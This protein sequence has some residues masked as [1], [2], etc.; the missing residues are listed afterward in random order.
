LP[1]QLA[2]P[3]ARGCSQ[4]HVLIVDDNVDIRGLIVSHFET[5]GIYTIGVAQ[6]QQL[7][8]YAADNR[9]DLVILDLSPPHGGGFEL[10]R[11]LRSGSGSAI[12]V[13][14]QCGEEA[15]RVVALEL[16][17]DDYV[18]KPVGLRELFARCRAVLR[19]RNTDRAALEQHQEPSGYRFGPWH[20]DKYLR[21]LSRTDGYRVT[22]SKTEYAL[23]VALLS[24]PQR[25]LSRLQLK[26]ATRIHDDITDRAMDVQIL[27]LRRKLEIDIR[28]PK[29]I[30][31]ER[32]IGYVFT[33]PVTET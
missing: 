14:G 24:A 6:R 28:S 25:P 4:H 8:R 11:E 3:A 26:R 29:M 7:A 20:L 9:P 22:L 12:I 32:D 33:Q 27:R 23:L 21:Q 30:R 13:T 1:T 5:Y 31:T 16:G 2:A 15:D 17:A 19:R 10:L 18:T